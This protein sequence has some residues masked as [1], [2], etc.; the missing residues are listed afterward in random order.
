MLKNVK[1]D[2]FTVKKCRKI[3]YC[4]RKVVYLH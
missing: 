4:H 3:F 2:A 1:K